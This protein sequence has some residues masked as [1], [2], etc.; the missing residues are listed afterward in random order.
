MVIQPAS[1]SLRM[2]SE[3]LVE[4]GATTPRRAGG[5]SCSTY[6]TIRTKSGSARQLTSS[7]R[8]ATHGNVSSPEP[9]VGK[10]QQIGQNALA[11]A[12]IAQAQR[13]IESARRSMVMDDA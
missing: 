11:E 4:L 8:R 13:D 9:A 12:V 1:P 10:D 6:A 7:S 3:T 5:R 2:T